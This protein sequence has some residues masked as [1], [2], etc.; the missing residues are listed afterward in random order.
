MTNALYFSVANTVLLKNGQPL[1]ATNLTQ[2]TNSSVLFRSN[3]AAGS[4][5]QHS[6]SQMTCVNIQLVPTVTSMQ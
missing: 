3:F 4:G 5:K 6:K 2:F 1:S